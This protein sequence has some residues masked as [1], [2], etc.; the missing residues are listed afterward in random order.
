MARIDVPVY[1]S[2]GSD[3]VVVT[4]VDIDVTD[5]HQVDTSIPYDKIIFYLVGDTDGV[6][7]EDYTLTFKA[8][9]GSLASLGDL[10]VEVLAGEFKEVTIESA[11]FKNSD[12]LILIDAVFTGA[13]VGAT[14]TAVAVD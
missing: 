3:S 4:P 5:D 6:T 8:G 10:S 2:N 14:I 7:P 1:N 9:V 11:R 12:G 13:L